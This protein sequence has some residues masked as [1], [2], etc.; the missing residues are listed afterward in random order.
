MASLPR[1]AARLLPKPKEQLA[2]HEIDRE[3]QDEDRAVDRPNV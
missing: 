1:V 3:R 2:D